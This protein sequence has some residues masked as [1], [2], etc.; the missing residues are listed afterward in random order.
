MVFIRNKIAMAAVSIISLLLLASS[1]TAFVSLTFSSVTTPS[2]IEPGTQGTLL[3]TISNT[4]TDFAGS[5]QLL[6]G[7]S[8]Y[9]STNTAI[10]NLP[11]LNAGGS[12]TITIPITIS[13]N[14]PTGTL[15]LPFTISYTTGTATGTVTTNNAATISVTKRTLIQLTDVQ[16]SES[17]IQ[18]G[19]NFTM[20]MTLQNV[21]SAQIKDLDVSLRNFSVAVVPAS[22]DT[23]KIITILSPGDS[24]TINF[25]L[26]A[27][28]STAAAA[29]SI[30][31]SLTYY[32][33]Q[34]NLHTDTKFAGMK[35]SGVPDF[36]VSLENTNVF[37]GQTNTLSVDVA[38][39]GT[40]SAKFVTLYADPNQGLT[41]Q[42]SYIGSLDPDSSSTV[43]LNINTQIKPGPQSFT[44]TVQYKDIYNQPYQE[45]KTLQFNSI[46]V[47]LQ[48]SNNVIIVAVV[49]I[50]A[51]LYWK[52]HFVK[53]LLK[54]K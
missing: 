14:A 23:E 22:T 51:L 28:P 47:P 36:V 25:N 19:D 2:V 50:V 43:S 3:L 18:P 53:N 11:S 32:D 42:V 8:P 31:V 41:P 9:V 13:A 10:F 54:K 48:I 7:S 38:N 49:V 27:L 26:L 6:V 39:V 37:A 30:P 46:N 44:L 1:A 21:G 15:T 17:V 40:G 52:R 33:D 45:T 24:T 12:T 5:P 29:Y 20:S 35:I 16:Y 34:G 4:G